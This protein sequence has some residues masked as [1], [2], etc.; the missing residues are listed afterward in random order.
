MQQWTGCIAGALTRAEFEQALA[1]AGLDRRSRSP[2]PTAS[3]RAPAR[4]SSARGSPEPSARRR[5]RPPDL[6][7]QLELLLERP[8]ILAG[9]Q[10]RAAAR[11]RAGRSRRA[12]GRPS[13]ARRRPPPRGRRSRRRTGRRGRRPPPSP[14]A[15]STPSACVSDAAKI[16][17]GGSGSASSSSVRRWA[18]S[19]PCGPVALQLVAHR[20]ARRGQRAAVALA[21]AGGSTR[22]RKPG[23]L[24]SPTNAIRSWPSSSRWRVASSPPWTSSMTTRG[25]RGCCAST[26]TTGAPAAS[27]ASTSS[28]CGASE[29]ISIPSERST[30]ARRP[31]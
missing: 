16:A 24:V 29:T 18:T 1:A 30:G 9:D 20:D 13:S 27:S 22:T 14:A 28:S 5:R 23:S 6:E 2:R 21:A 3:T 15:S 31:R 7:P 19:R 11:A 8:G 25:S 4:R 12:A 10:R 17:V 26:S